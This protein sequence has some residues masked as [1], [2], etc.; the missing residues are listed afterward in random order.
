[1]IIFAPQSVDFGLFA[2]PS[3]SENLKDCVYSYSGWHLTIETT[4]RMI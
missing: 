4:W 1:M 3:L 2:L